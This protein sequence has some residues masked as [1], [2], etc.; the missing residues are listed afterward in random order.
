VDWHDQGFLLVV[1]RHGESSA[2][3]EVFTA[4]HGRHAGVVK[5]GGSRR[6]APTLQP[7]AQVAVQWT[8]R[9]EEHIGMFRVDPVR[10]RAGLMADGVALA[11]LGSVLALL[12][13]ALPER[14]AHPAL[15]E[16]TLALLD[17]IEKESDWPAHY[18]RW[19]FELLGQLGF[20][21]D[22][23]ACATTGVREGLAFVSP[24]TGRAVS[25]AGAGEWADRLLPL[26]AFLL[27][28]TEPHGRSDVADALALSGFFLERRLAPMLQHER[29]PPARGRAVSA[30]LAQ[31]AYG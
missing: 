25:R 10:S 17:A 30:I 2:I 14:E 6:M 20:G 29:L 5:G 7:G 12:V 3:V 28:G 27:A 22:L 24:R 9:L 13:V 8:A 23:D 26:P 11:A 16:S 15:Y 1:R 4:E 21:L 31:L 19:E 18:A